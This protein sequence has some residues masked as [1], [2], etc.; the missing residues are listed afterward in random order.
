MPKTT[1]PEHSRRSHSQLCDAEKKLQALL[2]IGPKSDFP[3]GEARDELVLT[4]EDWI[5]Q[6]EVQGI[7]LKTGHSLLD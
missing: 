7:N 1:S 4:R 5:A 3:D 2:L 6:A